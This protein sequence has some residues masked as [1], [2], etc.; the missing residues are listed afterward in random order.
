MRRLLGRIALTCA[1]LAGAAV[2]PAGS[3]SATTA[4]KVCATPSGSDSSGSFATADPAQEN[5]DAAQLKAA[6]TM[7][8]L[9]LR[10][11]VQVFRNNCLVATGP[12]DAAGGSLHNN[13]W[14]VTKSVV[15][16]LTGIAV[17]QGKLHLDDPIDRYLPHGPGWGDA[18]HRAITVRQLLTQTSGLRQ[19]ILS[20]AATTGTDPH[21]AQEALSQ[22]FVHEPGTTFQY[23]QLGPALLAYV[24]QRAVGQDLVAF[25]QQRLFGPIGIKP[26]SYFWLRDRSGN[27]YG[28]A[29]LFLTPRQLARLALLMS[30]N[31][32]WNGSRIVSASY[33][34]AVSEPSPTNGCYGLL[35]W[36]NRGKPCTGADIPAAQTLQR[37]AVPSAPA[38]TYEMN[39]TGGQL[40]IMIPSL[41]M[42]VVTT[43]Y[44]GSLSLDPPVLLGSAPDEMQWTFFRALMAAVEDTHVPDPG[45][46]PGDPIDLDVNPMNYLDPG[47]LLSDA[48][49]NPYC[50]LVFCN[51]TV[52]TKGLLQNLQS[53]PGLL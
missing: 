36:T 29:H 40:A 44:F 34:A 31:G 5:L 14:S 7:L 17:D 12:L 27:A 38:D 45:P 10:L 19:S 8:S 35:F 15:S 4:P 46:Y 42:T 23:S 47:V 26:G 28:Y 6:V 25:A 13:L 49:T 18:A 3:A 16:M 43:G 1:M 39:G 33:V 24:V 37:H 22:P 53:L 32:R 2:V 50:N 30:N 9:R 41:H 21:L 51:G 52:P 48:I 11:S 20:E